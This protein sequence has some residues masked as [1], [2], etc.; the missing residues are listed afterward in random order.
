M[1]RKSSGIPKYKRLLIEWESILNDGIAVTM[2][3]ILSAI[4]I[5]GDSI[6]IT[7]LTKDVFW[8]IAGAA[9]IGF[10]LARIIRVILKYWHETNPY[11]KV[12]MWIIIAYGWFLLAE[13]LHASGIIAVFVWALYLCIS[14]SKGYKN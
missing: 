2:F 3:T 13:S 6:G 7:Q 9:C 12:N 10:I 8:N 1:L 14:S 11:L 4:I 5:S